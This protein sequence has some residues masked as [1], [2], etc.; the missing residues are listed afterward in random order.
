MCRKFV[1]RICENAR[2]CHRIHCSKVDQDCRYFL[3]GKCGYGDY[4]RFVH[5]SNHP[6]L[7]LNVRRLL[8]DPIH[9]SRY[10]Y[11][12]ASYVTTFW[13]VDVLLGTTAVGS[14]L[15]TLTSHAMYVQVYPELGLLDANLFCRLL[16]QSK[17]NTQAAQRCALNSST[18]IVLTQAL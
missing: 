7:G 8:A 17:R 16:T 5:P 14:T 10:I 4:C 18:W 6:A 13:R 12:N 2:H 9:R 15:E 3:E 11:R 1:F